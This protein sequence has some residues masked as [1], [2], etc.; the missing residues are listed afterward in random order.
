MYNCG[1]E[2]CRPEHFYGPAVRD[3]YLIHV[4]RSGR[5][6]FQVGDRLYPLQ[7]GQAF[8][9]CPDVVTFYQADREEP[10]HY[11]WLGFNGTQASRYLEAAGLSQ[12]DP[13]FTADRDGDGFLADC[14]ARMVAAQAMERGRETQVKGLLYLFLS[15]LIASGR[16][17]DRARNELSKSELYLKQ[18]VEFIRMNYSRKITVGQIAA[19]VGLDRSYLCFLFKERLRISPQQ[20]LIRFRMEKACALMAEAA[21]SIG[22]IARSVGYDDPLQFSKSFR[23]WSGLPPSQFRAERIGDR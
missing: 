19:F 13:V 20:F 21:L 9:I 15:R 14:I 23:K 10:W 12:A 11:S 2:D 22:D 17:E 6:R 3:H 7:A 8:L 4:I 18:A 1:M 16:G 5:G